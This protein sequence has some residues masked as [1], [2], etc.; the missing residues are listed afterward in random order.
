MIGHDDEG[1]AVVIPLGDTT[2]AANITAGEEMG[3]PQLA[4]VKLNDKPATENF[5]AIFTDKPLTLLFAVGML[6]LDGSFRKLTAD[7]R[8]RIEELRKEAAPALLEFEGEKENQTAI[9]RLTEERG[10][11]PVLFDITLK[12]RRP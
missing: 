7:E 8:R 3:L 9:V 6:P 4:R 11:R 1:N 12:L 5:T 10:P 2:A